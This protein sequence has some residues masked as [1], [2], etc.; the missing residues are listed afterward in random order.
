MRGNLS[1]WERRLSRVLS[2]CGRCGQQTLDIDDMLLFM[3]NQAANDLLDCDRTMH[4]VRTRALPLRIGNTSQYL[5][6]LMT[7]TR[8]AVEQDV[9]RLLLVTTNLDPSPLIEPR[10]RRIV[11]NQ[12]LVNPGCQDFIRCPQVSENLVGGPRSLGLLVPS[13]GAAPAND[14]IQPRYSL[15]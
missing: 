9:D 1:V 13:T 7:L 14:M 4:F 5:D 3:S 2:L 6:Q 11:P 15:R 8:Y 12:N 10:Q